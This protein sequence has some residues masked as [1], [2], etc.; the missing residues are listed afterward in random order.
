MRRFLSAPAVIVVTLNLLAQTSPLPGIPE[1]H[2]ASSCIVGG[3]VVKAAEGSPLKSARVSLVPEHS[4]FKRQIYATT[5]D[6]DG[7]F[8][9]KDVVPGRYQFFATRAGFVNQQYQAKGNDDGAVLSLKPGETVSDVLFRMTV[10]GV[11]TGRVTNEDGEA[12]IRVQVVALRG[13]SEDEIEDEASFT[14]RKRDLRAVSS[15]Q[16]DDRG[17]YRIFGLKPGEYYIKVTDSFEPDRNIAV[18]EGYWVQQFLGSEYAPVYFPDV[19]QAS[20]AQVVSVK[21]GSEVQADVLMQRIKTVEIAGHVIGRD[22]PAKNTWVLLAQHGMDDSGIDR[23]DT[24][25]EKGTFRLKGVPPGSY[26][27]AAY[28]RDEGEGVYEPRGQE[29]VEVSGENIDSLT[30]SLGG[31][32]NVQGRVTVAGGGSPTLDRIGIGFSGIDED[33]QLGAQGRVKKDGTFEIRSVNDGNYAISVWG[34]ESNWYVKSVRLGGDEILEKGLQLEKGG[35]GG[36]LEVVVSSASA[37]LDGSVIDHYG[38]VIGAHVRV[39]PEPETPYNRSRSHSVRTDQ[40]GHFSLTGLAPGTYRL[41]AK[42]PASPGSSTL[43]SDPQIVTLSEH[44]HKAVQLTIV[45]PQAE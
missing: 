21:A 25:D 29:K 28:Q 23:Q 11:V 20:Q 38:A 3:R 34:L 9:L 8:L 10:S 41:L 18:D 40:S 22:G 26:V 43:R 27:I 19:A 4:E 32:T 16:T 44:D 5:S 37:Q 6:S 12:M 2:P 31:G 17:Q 14:S 7:H 15:A 36:R 1:G 45:K 39:S 42:Y 35:S 24:T 13:P 33:E 30:I